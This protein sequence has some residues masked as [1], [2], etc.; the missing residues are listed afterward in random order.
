MALIQRINTRGGALA[1]ASPT[2]AQGPAIT[3]WF[4]ARR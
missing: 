4:D 3:P 1:G 2:V